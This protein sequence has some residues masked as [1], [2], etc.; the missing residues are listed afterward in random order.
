MASNL[1][2]QPQ[3]SMPLVSVPLEAEIPAA[4]LPQINSHD[5]DNGLTEP[6]A[7][8]TD[9]L[10][11]LPDPADT[12]NSEIP[13]ESGSINSPEDFHMRLKSL[14][15]RNEK[16]LRKPKRA[17]SDTQ[18]VNRLFD[19]EAL[20]RYNGFR[21]G[22]AQK[23]RRLH[24]Q[25]SDAPPRER[26][27]MRT[28]MPR[29]RPSTD[30]SLTAAD[31]AGKGPYYAKQ[32]RKMAIFLLDNGTLPESRRGKGAVHPSLLNLPEVQ[33]GL[34]SW[35]NGIFKVEEGGFE[36]PVRVSSLH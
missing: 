19:L 36:G 27:K 32:L 31:A 1:A 16:E 34:R 8:E 3:S 12:E 20:K 35:S 2:V 33:E 24:Q 15:T 4:V 9:E 11:C 26:E 23:L 14:I 17:L 22:H 10:D 18:A 29:I 21:L 30:A 5:S 13:K 6:A 7:E 28:E 25:I